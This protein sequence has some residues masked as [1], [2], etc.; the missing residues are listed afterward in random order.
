[1]NDCPSSGLLAALQKTIPAFR[2]E[3]TLQCLPGQRLLITGPSGAGKTTLLRCLTG[4][5]E[6]DHGKIAVQ[7]E[8]W[9]DSATHVKLP[10][11]HRRVG[12]LSQ[13]FLLF[14]HMTIKENVR[15]AM[16]EENYQETLLEDAGIA[17]LAGRYPH[18]LSGGE[19]QRA[20]ICQV[21]ARCPQL[22]LLDEPFSA[23]DLENRYRLRDIFTRYQQ[24]TGAPIL[25]VTHD[26]AEVFTG[27]D[28]VLCL[29]A[30]RENPAW[31]LRQQQ[32][33]LQVVT[34]AARAA[35]A[36]CYPESGYKVMP[37]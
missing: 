16:S 29:V 23:L 25:E 36:P 34:P 21:L 6:L 20:A 1:M 31:L 17:H 28:Q 9:Y 19:R 8:C 24:K 12:F 14:P 26:L 30:A 32:F 4:L 3:V 22:I 7:N 10:T 5:E 2:L 33:F 37:R 35:A 18:Q 15:F 13:D 11:R 27:T